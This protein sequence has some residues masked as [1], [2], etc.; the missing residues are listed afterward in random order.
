MAKPSRAA[1]PLWGPSGPTWP[2][3]EA[4]ARCAL[5]AD[6]RDQ[7]RSDA[8]AQALVRPPVVVL[9]SADDQYSLAMAPAQDLRSIRALPFHRSKERFDHSVG[10]RHADRGL[11]G[12]A[13]WAQQRD[14]MSAATCRCDREASRWVAKPSRSDQ[15]SGQDSAQSL[16]SARV[17]TRD[18]LAPWCGY[19]AIGIVDDLFPFPVGRAMQAPARRDP[20]LSTDAQHGFPPGPWSP[21]ETGA[22]TCGARPQAPKIHVDLEPL[23]RSRALTSCSGRPVVLLTSRVTRPR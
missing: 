8:R 12:G 17:T 19:Q 7:Y 20:N 13:H 22:T 15:S 16:G 14:Q 10:S 23:L 11:N 2:P 9:G 18:Q 3:G 5:G 1:P 4:D 21:S 6:R